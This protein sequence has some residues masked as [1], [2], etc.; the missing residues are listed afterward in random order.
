MA[1]P[2]AE[3]AAAPVAVIPVAV[4]TPLRVKQA[5]DRALLDSGVA[6]LTSSYA[7]D[8]LR[9]AAGSVAGIVMANRS[10]RQAVRAKVVV[11]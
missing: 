3:Q 9:D 5:L 8:V 6:F 4:P 1:A 11:D 2:E 7:T 10:G